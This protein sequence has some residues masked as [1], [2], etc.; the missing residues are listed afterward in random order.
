MNEIVPGAARP[1]Q[2]RV[3][4]QVLV[5]VAAVAVGLW[6]LY[7]LKRVVLVLILAMFF[8]YA[9]EPVVRFAERPVPVGGRLRVLPRGLAILC[10]YVL[11]L[12]AAATAVSFLLPTA[13]QQVNDAIASA[14]GYEQ[15]FRSWERGWTRYY[16]HLRLPA[17]LREGIDRSAVAAGTAS[18][19][20]LRG[21]VMFLAGGVAYLPWLI[22]IPVLAFFLLREAGRLRGV[23]EGAVPVGARPRAHRLIEDVNTTIAAYMR[24]QL[25]ACVVV[26]SL[27]GV[28]FSMLGVPYAVLL[29]ILA[30]ALEFVPLFG[31]V[32][33]AVFATVVAALR[34]PALAL[35]VLGFLAVLR[36]VEDYVIYPRLIGRHIDLHPIAIVLAVL[37]GVELGGAVG[38]FVAVPLLAVGSVMTRHWW[39]WTDK[40]DGS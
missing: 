35:P 21:G 7:R 39:H 22:L 1:S 40:R 20:Y 38:I 23:L 12:A 27:C 11:L 36:V 33:L 6:L 14:P 5:A 13:T 17:E 37:A 19:D 8:A 18:V 29:G 32:A 3:A 31:P 15:S 24:A 25:L 34:A 10:V 16:D 9:I 4:L 2:A 26:G 28:A 30:A